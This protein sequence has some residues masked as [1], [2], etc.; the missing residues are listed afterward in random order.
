MSI[1]QFNGTYDLK[2]DRILFRFN[3]QDDREFRFWLT[4]FISKGFLN[5]VDQ[6]IQKGLEQKHNPQ[7]AEVIKDFQQDGLAKT[8]S[9]NEAY[10]GASAFP[11]GEDPILVVAMNFNLTG[12]L[13]SMDF[14]F[15]D[16]RNLN[17]KL[18]IASVQKMALLIGKLCNSA[19]W[20]INLESLSVP[21][22]QANPTP[23]P[24]GGGKLMH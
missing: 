1:K 14:Q 6:L 21:A 16:K 2:E 13:F 17:L 8:T 19:Q 11:L 18:P 23:E 5:A 20:Q 15:S 10:Q 24:S 12:D 7:I 3:T 22:P 4:R 9:T